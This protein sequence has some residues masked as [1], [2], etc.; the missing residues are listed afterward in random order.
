MT[1]DDVVCALSVAA[2]EAQTPEGAR[3]LSAAEVMVR[4]TTLLNRAFEQSGLTQRELA[5]TLGVTE[6]RVSQVLN[7]D[8]NVR[9]STLA[10]Y[11]R[12][13]GYL[14][15]I[16]ADPATP[17]V[18]PLVPPRRK[19]SRRQADV[20]DLYVTPIQHLGRPEFKITALPT[21]EPVTAFEKSTATLVGRTDSWIEHTSGS[22]RLEL[23]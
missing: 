8:G 18:P 1:D 10:R 15:R 13:T 14:T 7:G 12:A 2:L 20:H 21:G 17:D 22:I 6:G 23:E 3:E 19:R 5:K 4:A 11:L 16:E 9:L